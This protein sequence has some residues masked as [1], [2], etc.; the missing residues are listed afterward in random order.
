MTSREVTRE[1]WR[2]GLTWRVVLAIIYGAV[3]LMPVTIWGELMIGAVRGLYWTA[4]IL[5]YWLSL[6]YGSPLTKQEI[7]LMFAATHTVVYVSTGL[8][9]HHM[10]YRVWFASSP[11]AEA[12]GVKEYIP[13]WWVPANP[14]IRTQAL[15]TFFDPSWLPV[16]SVSLLFWML[17]LASGLSLGFLFYQL[18]VEVERLPFPMAQVD[19]EVITELVERE[20][21]RMRIFVLFALLGFIYSLIAYGV[22]VLSQT[23]IGVPITVIPYPWYDLT[24]SFKEALPGAMIGIDTNL[25]NYMLGMILPIEAVVCMFI[26]SF[27]TSIIG[28]PIVVW[29]FP[30]LIPEWVGFPKGMKLAD[31]LFWSNIYIWYA[32]SIG[33]SFA[34]FIES[35]IRYRKGFITSIKSLARLSAESKCIGYI[36]LYK[37][38]GI[39]FASTLLWFALLETVLIP[40]FPVLPLL[41][42]IV[43]WPFI[44]GLVST[45][46]YAETGISLVIPYFHNNFLTLTLEAYHIPVYSELGI[47]SWFVPMGVDPG[48]GWTSTLYVCRGVKCTFRSYIKAVFLIATPIAI[49]LNLLYSEYLWKMTPIPSP[50]FQ[51]A[52]IF[53]P[54]Q[55]AQSMLWI[56][57]KIYSFNLNL[58]LGGFTS[59]L[60]AS[61]V[62]MTLKVPFSSVA[63]VVGLTQPLPTPLAIFLGAMLSRIIEKLSKGRINLRKYA[64]MMLGGYIV[65]LSV[66]MA[67]SVSLSIFVKSLW[68][69]PY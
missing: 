19:V 68:P 47:W 46:A 34:V 27:V 49:I 58:M 42:V 60:A 35:L 4:V 51:Y 45:R 40:G 39:Y 1:E 52:Q 30:E 26:G 31:I 43:I 20:P 23:F 41:F 11:I 37:L 15:R 50:M 6:L 12:Y 29:Y 44:Y 25:A 63:L 2:S 10:F 21:M 66:A 61:L 65:G 13:Y 33:G 3:V 56:T 28:N 32:V 22:P 59:V 9:F 55:A 7:L 69:L 57:R 24:E 17:N 18:F 36:S 14:L 8:N 48:V 16:I 54:I 67:L 38:I 64:F 5:F 53:W 62:A